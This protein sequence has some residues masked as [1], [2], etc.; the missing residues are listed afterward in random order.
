MLFLLLVDLLTEGV[1]VEGEKY[2]TFLEF[3]QLQF[4]THKVIL[5]IPN[6]NVNLK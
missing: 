2:I 1:R 6:N 5:V 4:A 3:R